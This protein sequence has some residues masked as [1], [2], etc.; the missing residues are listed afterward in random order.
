MHFFLPKKKKKRIKEE[1]DK[2]KV[3]NSYAHSRL[4]N[5]LMVFTVVFPQ[6]CDALKCEVIV[7]L[8]PYSLQSSS[9]ES[10]VLIKIFMNGL[11]LLCLSG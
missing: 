11:K 1:G 5:F 8:V 9:V 10:Q 6:M 7:F 4:T 2:E 3:N